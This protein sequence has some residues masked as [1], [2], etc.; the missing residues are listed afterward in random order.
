MASRLNRID[1]TT[2]TRC[3][4]EQTA[5]FWPNKTDNI[6]I[7]GKTA[8]RTHDRSKGKVSVEHRHYISSATYPLDRLAEATRGHWTVENHVHWVLDLEFKDDLARYRVPHGVKTWRPSAV[9]LST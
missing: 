5:T 1:P 8:R 3:L 7:D 4:D 9:S 6:A 2:F